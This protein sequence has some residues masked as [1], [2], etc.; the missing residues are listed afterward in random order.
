LYKAGKPSYGVDTMIT[1]G[2]LGDKGQG[3]DPG[4][5]DGVPGQKGEAIAAP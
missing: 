5:N 3:G 4:N 1:P 2:T